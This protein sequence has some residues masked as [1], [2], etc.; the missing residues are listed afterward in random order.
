MQSVLIVFSGVPF[1]DCRVLIKN[2][3]ACVLPKIEYSRLL[4][5]IRA[6]AVPDQALRSVA[7][8]LNRWCYATEATGEAGTQLEQRVELFLGV[9]LCMIER[10][11]A[12]LAKN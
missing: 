4:T 6:R 9:L 7:E 10:S 12:G 8:S 3:P 1:H 5:V 11:M 2:L